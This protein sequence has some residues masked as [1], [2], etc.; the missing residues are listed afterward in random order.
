M[1]TYRDFSHNQV[2]NL[3]S[4]TFEGLIE[5]E[6]L[7]LRANKINIIENNVWRQL[8]NLKQLYASVFEPVLLYIGYS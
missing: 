6:H 8:E 4:K 7:N 1:V 3:S 2:S 5:V